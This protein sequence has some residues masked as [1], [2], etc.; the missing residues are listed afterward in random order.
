M[1]FMTTKNLVMN[2]ARREAVKI[3]NQLRTAA[4]ATGTANLKMLLNAW[5]ATWMEK[6]EITAMKRVITIDT[7][8]QR[9]IG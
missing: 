1:A 7:R 6:K 3:K 9:I 2:S 5:L 4:R 8:K